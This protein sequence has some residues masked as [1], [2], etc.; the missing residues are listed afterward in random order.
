M[1]VL[2]TG[3]AGFIGSHTAGK[4]CAE[5]YPVTVLDN[6]TTGYESNL[7]NLVASSRLRFINGDICDGELVKRLVDEADLV[8]HLAAMA[9]VPETIA[10]PLE[11]QA[12]NS[13]ATLQLL[14]T[15]RH[16]GV[17]RFV[18]ASSAA[19]YGNSTIIPQSEGLPV[20]PLSPYA[21]QKQ[22]GERYAQLYWQ[23]YKLPTVSLRFFNVFGPR[24]RPDSAYSG[25]ISRFGEAFAL[26]QSPVVFGDGHQSR[27]F[28]YV[29]NVVEAIWLAAT[30]PVDRVAGEVFNV[31][32][33]ES[34]SLLDLIEQFKA[35]T[36]RDLLVEHRPSRAGDVR[37][38][39]SDLNHSQERLGYRAVIGWRE[40]LKKTWDYFESLCPSDTRSVTSGPNSRTED[41]Q[42][43]QK[44]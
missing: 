9:S 16:A 34:I 32:T 27:D 11:S 26:G 31:G 43:R 18:F 44:D 1:R 5:G 2:I 25:V 17:K 30:Q 10:H 24:Q 12:I 13:T 4:F 37:D 15:A 21:L 36:G 33:G 35:I 14:E 20:H 28:V 8:V 40:G 19:V 7:E 23:L 38:S 42:E 41:C 22:N 3:G 39:R 6:L 29:T